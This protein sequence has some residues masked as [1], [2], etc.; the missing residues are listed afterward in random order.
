[1]NRRIDKCT[2]CGKERKIAAHSLCFACYRQIERTIKRKRGAEAIVQP[3]DK[4][5]LR[6]YVAAINNLVEMGVSREDILAI[7]R[8]YLDPCVS[9]VAVYLNISSEERE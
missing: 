9:S 8:S 2:S 4:R 5:L 7:K 3:D 1:V 6:V